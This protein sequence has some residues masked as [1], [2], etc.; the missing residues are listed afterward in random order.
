MRCK[1]QVY[2]HL[3]CIALHPLCSQLYVP[4]FPLVNVLLIYPQFCSPLLYP[5][6]QPKGTGS[7]RKMR[8]SRAGPGP[9]GTLFI[10]TS[11]GRLGN[12]GSYPLPLG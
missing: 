11:P 8:C 12:R 3:I 2:F 6:P 1:G 5:H 9:W 10:P 7:G 4:L